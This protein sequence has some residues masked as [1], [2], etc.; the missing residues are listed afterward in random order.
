MSTRV[1]EF[2]IASKRSWLNVKKELIE[3]GSELSETIIIIIF[4]YIFQPTHIEATFSRL[5]FDVNLE[6]GRNVSHDQTRRGAILQLYS[7][8]S[9]CASPPP[10][11]LRSCDKKIVSGFTLRLNLFTSC[12]SCVDLA[13]EN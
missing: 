2:V 8:M 10:F 7:G 11:F 5:R 12:D 4:H 6:T 13:L 1:R 9:D 3:V